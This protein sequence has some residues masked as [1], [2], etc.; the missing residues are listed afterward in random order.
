MENA[1]LRA[2]DVSNLK[3]TRA[4]GKTYGRF[5]PS[6]HSVHESARPPC[7][8]CV[9]ASRGCLWCSPH[10][11]FQQGSG[12]HVH[13][14]PRSFFGHLSLGQVCPPVTQKTALVA[15]TGSPQSRR[16]CR[17]LSAVH[18]SCPL[19]LVTTTRMASPKDCAVLIGSH[20]QQDVA[21]SVAP[22]TPS[23]F[24]ISVILSPSAPTEP[25][26]TNWEWFPYEEISLHTVFSAPPR[27]HFLK[28]QE[29]SYICG[30]SPVCCPR[31]VGAFASDTCVGYRIIDFAFPPPPFYCRVD[32]VRTCLPV[33]AIKTHPAPREQ[34]AHT[35]RGTA[36]ELT[37][38]ETCGRRASI[39][40]CRRHFCPSP[41]STTK[42]RAT[43]TA[44]RGSR[45]CRMSHVAGKRL[46]R[47]VPTPILRSNSHARRATTVR[48]IPK[49]L[50]CHH[51]PARVHSVARFCSVRITITF[52]DTPRRRS[53]QTFHPSFRQSDYVQHQNNV[54]RLPCGRLSRPA[55]KPIQ[56]GALRKWVRRTV[57]LLDSATKVT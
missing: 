48:V 20:T 49:E 35:S 1:P 50:D 47:H 2:E 41:W 32:R 57:R 5:V 13:C 4:T 11:N 40:R 28:T 45:P 37:T 54:H 22:S 19:H 31:S 38:Q 56:M 17:P 9:H 15:S 42:W 16:S 7:H 51:Q 43:R 39:L 12:A 52:L 8:L 36:G 25:E 3:K 10:A 33:V 46:C 21:I 30:K 14:C 27:G 53:T 29:R 55:Q 26:Y 34:T 18:V 23:P 24:N 44:C 6:D